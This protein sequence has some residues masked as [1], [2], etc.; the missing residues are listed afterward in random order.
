MAQGNWWNIYEKL[1][2]GGGKRR[3]PDQVI[4]SNDE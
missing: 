1:N 2:V 4:S 3:I